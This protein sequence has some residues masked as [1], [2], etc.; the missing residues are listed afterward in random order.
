[1]TAGSAL[2]MVENDGFTAL[3]FDPA[4]PYTIRGGHQP[5]MRDLSRSAE[6]CAAIRTAVGD[7]VDLLLGT[8]G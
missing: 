5:A 4:G 3:K 2:T 1:M 8:H 7:R 6:F